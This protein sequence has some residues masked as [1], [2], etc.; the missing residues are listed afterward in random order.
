MT[1][2]LLSAP[3]QEPVTL[4]EAKEFL[5]VDGVEEDGFI[6]SLIVAARLHVESITSR[7]M[8]AQSWRVICDNFPSNKIVNLPVAPLLSLTQVRVYDFDGNEILLALAQFQPETKVSPA[9]IFLPKTIAGL[10]LMRERAAVEIDYVAGF[11]ASSDDVPNDLKQA[12]FVLIAYWFE[13]RDAVIIAG[14]G[15][16]VPVGFDGLVASYRS[17]KL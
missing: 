14:S 1:S 6:T 10:P 4:V 2:Y 11:G 7:A 17:V 12:I 13:H 8:I 3:A 16:V 9:R 5:R 15:S